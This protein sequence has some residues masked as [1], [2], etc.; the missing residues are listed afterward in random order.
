MIH[1]LCTTLIIVFTH[2]F[3]DLFQEVDEYRNFI[4]QFAIFIA[5]PKMLQ[6]AHAKECLASCDTSML[7]THVTEME[8]AI[9]DAYTKYAGDA[10]K[11]DKAIENAHNRCVKKGG[12][13]STATTAF[14]NACKQA[15]VNRE[16]HSKKRQ[17]TGKSDVES[18]L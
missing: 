9:A 6:E 14:W 2:C 7:R 4:S 3:N 5:D 16:E 12:D 8:A 11:R 13:P 17:K 18:C 1:I 15:L 10:K